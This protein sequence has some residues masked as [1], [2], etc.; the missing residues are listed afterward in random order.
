MYI[1]TY[2]LHTYKRV[3]I[4]TYIHTYLRILTYSGIVQLESPRT[5]CIYTHLGVHIHTYVSYTLTYSGTVQLESP[6]TSDKR[7]GKTVFTNS[8]PTSAPPND[9]KSKETTCLEGFPANQFKA[10]CPV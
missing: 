9:P 1:H 7:P 2:V 8:S 4:H 5:I 6:R 3:Y 10:L